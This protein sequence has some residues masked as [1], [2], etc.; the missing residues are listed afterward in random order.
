MING[1]GPCTFILYDSIGENSKTLGH[2]TCMFADPES[3][4]ALAGEKK[5]KGEKRKI[6]KAKEKRKRKRKR[7]FS[8]FLGS[9]GM[10]DS[11]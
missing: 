1:K 10:A 2:N 4:G 5:S 9:N 8:F 7:E 11:Y 6:E 3:E